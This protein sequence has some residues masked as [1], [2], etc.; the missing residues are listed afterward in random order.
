MSKSTGNVAML[1]DLVDQGLLPLS[2]RYF[3]L[4][5]H[6][7]KQQTFTDEAIVAADRGY[8]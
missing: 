3:F 1:Q 6:Y 7:R 8:R 4:Q 2:Y 5:A